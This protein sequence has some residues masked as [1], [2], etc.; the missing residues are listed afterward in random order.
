VPVVKCVLH[1][2]R[3]LLFK[4]FLFPMNL[5]NKIC[6]ARRMCTEC[7][8]EVVAVIVRYEW[9]LKF[10]MHVLFCEILQYKI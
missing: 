7:S 1:S 6:D 9:R 2:V 8:H 10:L 3:Q 4:I 5:M